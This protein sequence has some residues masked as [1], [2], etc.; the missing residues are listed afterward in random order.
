[1]YHRCS[2]VC[3]ENEIRKKYKVEEMG[4]QKA[5]AAMQQLFSITA[6]MRSRQH[7][8]MDGSS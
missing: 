6:K 7:G 8:K 5:V 3:H 2:V 4:N 1:M